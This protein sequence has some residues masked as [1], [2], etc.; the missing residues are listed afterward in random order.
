[1]GVLDHLCAHIGYN[2]QRDKPPEDGETNRPKITLSFRN[3]IR[4]SRRL[5]TFLYDSLF[6]NVRNYTILKYQ[7]SRCCYHL[8][9]MSDL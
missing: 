7:F 6:K 3:S 4:N 2:R 8:T 5:R 9:F 1:M